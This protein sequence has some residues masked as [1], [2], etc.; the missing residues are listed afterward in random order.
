MVIIIKTINDILWVFV[1][2]VILFN[3]IYFSIK[4][5]FPQSRFMKILK[6]LKEED[7]KSGISSLDTL[8]M[9]LAAKI[10]VGSLAGISYAIYYG[11]IGV[12]FW[13]F[14]FSFLVSIN[15][16]L[17]NYLAIKYKVR[18][19]K[20][21][22]GGPA[23]YI[24]NGLNKKNLSLIYAFVLI[25]TFL[26]GFLTI[27]NNTITRFV[28]ISYNI[29]IVLTSLIITIISFY[30]I[31]RGLKS[32]SK[33]CNN[34]VPIMSIVYIIIGIII[35]VLN[36]D[37]IDNF[38]IDIITS[39][40]NHKSFFG[41]FL[42]CL[43]I[44]IQKSIFSSE[45]GLGTGAISSA[46]SSCDEPK[47]QGYIGIIGTYFINIVITFLTG[48]IV[49]FSDYKSMLFNNVNGIEITSFA[50]SYHLGSFGEAIL[51]ILIILFAFSSIVTGYYYLES[52]L[53]LF[54]NS[55]LI[56]FILKLV[57][58]IVLFYGGILPSNTIWNI[59]DL[60]V[61]VL[62]LINIYAIFKLRHVIK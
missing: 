60:C 19:G 23:Y 9:S 54:T 39:S 2:I 11:G 15:S 55:K 16:Y 10:G 53:K 7:K 8:F 13:I 41:G 58:I 24:K 62:S 36:F 52:N 50:F 45:A 40:F 4:L 57:T 22:K 44:S 17:E 32:I 35:L 18:D 21:Y 14:I 27:Q 25:F 38:F 47:K 46:T 43:I 20:F 31:L 26:F 56:I 1:V 49:Y 6:T 48:F 29:P 12:I 34:I 59:I 42:S 3:S 30:F 5:K 61:G 37:R 51:L 33:L 28:N